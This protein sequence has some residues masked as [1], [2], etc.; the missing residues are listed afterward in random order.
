MAWPRLSSV[1]SHLRSGG[2][3]SAATEPPAPHPLPPPVA[4]HP[5]S[6]LTA[7]EI[8]AAAAVVIRSHGS[9]IGSVRFDNVMLEEPCKQA[10]RRGAVA[11]E[12][13]VSVYR[14]AENHGLGPGMWDGIVNLDSGTVTSWRFLPDAMPM[15]NGGS[16]IG[17]MMAIREN[18]E[19]KAA[20]ARRG[21]TDPK[22][23]VMEPWPTGPTAKTFASSPFD[24]SELEPAS[25][26]EAGKFT[27]YTHMWYQTGELDNYYAHPID[28]LKVVIDLQTFGE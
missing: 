21:I 24:Y 18:T 4:L 13:H 11:R 9:E 12:A 27:A 25:V 17:S 14:G 19:V 22:K 20:L 28:G 26:L 2:A 15:R 1:L 6:P 3:A 23:V 10:L 8:E 5:T 7:A 16:W